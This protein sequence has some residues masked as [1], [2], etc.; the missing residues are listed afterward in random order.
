MEPLRVLVVE[1]R[2]WADLVR[3]IN[4]HVEA[5]TGSVDLRFLVPASLFVGGLVRLIASK[6]DLGR[7]I[8]GDL[9]TGRP[10]EVNTTESA[11]VTV[12]RRERPT[13]ISTSPAL[14]GRVRT[15]SGCRVS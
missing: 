9:P 10:H 7:L 6:K 3:K 11:Q 5:T 1:E 2:L 13:Q 12:V 4:A 15:F 14:V 8:R